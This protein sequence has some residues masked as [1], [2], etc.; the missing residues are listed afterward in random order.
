MANKKGSPIGTPAAKDQGKHG[1]TE[2]LTKGM[3]E[4]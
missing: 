1:S 2:L 3:E 4:G